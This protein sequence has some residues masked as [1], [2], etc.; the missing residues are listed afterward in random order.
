MNPINNFSKILACPECRNSLITIANGLQ[1]ESC[2]KQ[3]QVYDDIPFFVGC[4]S[5]KEKPAGKIKKNYFN[6]LLKK[7]IPL[8]LRLHFGLMRPFLILLI[9]SRIVQYLIWGREQVYLIIRFRFP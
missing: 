9:R 6:E 8:F 2:K 7:Y 3:Y 5:L 4:N 1:C